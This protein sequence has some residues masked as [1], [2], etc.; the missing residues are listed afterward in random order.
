VEKYGTYPEFLGRNNDTP[1]INVS[2]EKHTQWQREEASALLTCPHFQPLPTPQPMLP[3]TSQAR[4]GMP[5]AFCFLCQ[6]LF[7]DLSFEIEFCFVTQAVYAPLPQPPK[8]WDY[9][10]V[11]SHCISRCLLSAYHKPGCGL[12]SFLDEWLC[13]SRLHP[14]CLV[15]FFQQP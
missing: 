13:V 10:C 3:S 15:F 8:C 6:S 1:P 11:P 12:N 2:S 4:C 7:F 14:H 9:S 5:T